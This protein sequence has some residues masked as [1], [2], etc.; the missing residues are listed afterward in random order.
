M[1]NETSGPS[2][3]MNQ[4]DIVFPIRNAGSF[5]NNN[6]L[7]YS[8]RSIEKHLH[9]YRK[10]WII[11]ERPLWLT[12]N[13]IHI[14][15]PDDFIYPARNIY[16]KIKK[17]CQYQELSEN[18]L[19]FNDDHF[20]LSDFNASEFPYFYR[21]N[22]KDVK[23]NTVYQETVNNTIR[24]LESRNLPTL[25][26]DTHTPILYNKARFIEITDKYH[27][28]REH[29]FCIKSIYCN[30]VGMQGT[31][32]EDGKFKLPKGEEQLNHWLTK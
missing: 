28:H 21:G 24:S 27:W 12:K 4:V 31:F 14:P 9:G 19:F 25:D 23:N 2:A 6:E 16:A 10:I 18:F 22:L 26:F 20:L 11:G 5:W 8:L 3:K 17:A 30:T 29:A 1:E 13:I 15:H 7:R 32:A